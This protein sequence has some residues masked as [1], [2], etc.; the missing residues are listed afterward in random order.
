MQ[1]SSTN[2]SLHFLPSFYWLSNMNRIVTECYNP[3]TWY[4]INPREAY[5]DLGKAP[6]HKL[7][8]EESPPH[9]HYITLFK[10]W[11]P[12][13]QLRPIIFF[14]F[15]NQRQA[16]LLSTRCCLEAHSFTLQRI[17][18]RFSPKPHPHWSSLV[19]CSMENGQ[20][21]ADE[22]RCLPL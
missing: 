5:T 19:T 21:F 1:H 18:S 14:F 10:Q 3:W 2:D 7:N 20:L 15:W 17:S 11:R 16:S 9:V 22:D 6:S 12:V 4:H 13:E 8:N